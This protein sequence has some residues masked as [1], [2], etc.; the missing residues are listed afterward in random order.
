MMQ[1]IW[2]VQH[3][4]IAATGQGLASIVIW[5][6]GLTDIEAEEVQR[7]PG[8]EYQKFNFSAYPSWMNISEPNRG[9]VNN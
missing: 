9:E 2:N 7:W 4:M 8:V 6:F 3:T 1:T 5:D